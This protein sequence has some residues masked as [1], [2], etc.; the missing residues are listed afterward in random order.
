MRKDSGF[1]DT[2]ELKSKHTF[3]ASRC[4][5]LALAEGKALCEL[6]G[7]PETR[8]APGW[9][10]ANVFISHSWVPSL[11]SSFS[12]PPSSSPLGLCTCYPQQEHSPDL[13]PRSYF[14]RSQ[15]DQFFLRGFP[16]PT[17]PDPSLC[18]TLPSLPQPLL[19]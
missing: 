7:P 13:T 5:S 9:P 19:A 17:E 14:A 11:L 10:P 3:A 12:M 6:T 15:F 4:L 2:S 18:P 16:P 1:P 8:L